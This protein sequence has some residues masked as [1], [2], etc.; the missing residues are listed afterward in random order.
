[1]SIEKTHFR[2]LFVSDIHLGTKLSKP[3]KLIEV[4]DNN[5]FDTIYLVGDIIDMIAMKRKVYWKKKHNKLI[6]KILKL[7]NKTDIRYIIGNHDY[8][9]EMLVDTSFGKIKILERDI[10]YLLDGTPCLIIHGH[11]FDGKLK[12]MTW[13]YGLGSFLYDISIGLNIVNEQVRKLLKLKEWSLSYYLKSKVKNKIGTL[14]EFE[15]L[16]IST[17]KEHNCDVV[18]AG[19]IHIVEDKMYDNI[20]YMNCGCVTEFTSYIVETVE[21]KLETIIL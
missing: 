4:L 3:E 16:M 1:M 14:M 5:T 17:A 9:M 2:T 6:K 10:H 18:I 21:G 13:L 15:K 12:S 8:F 20:R 19:H 7:S 11:Q